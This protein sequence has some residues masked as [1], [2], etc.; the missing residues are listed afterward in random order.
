MASLGGNILPP[1]MDFK[2]FFAGV[3]AVFAVGILLSRLITNSSK[4]SDDENPGL[5]KSLLLF[6]Y[7]CFIKPHESGAK[8]TQQDALESFYKKQA[9]VYDATRKTLLKG[10]EDMLGLVAAHVTS[11][12]EK[13]GQEKRKRIWVD[14]CSAPSPSPRW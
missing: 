5:V 13:D 6:G 2:L 4:K 11:K 10:R 12:A 9:G 14:V 3:A 8:G 1:H 7:S